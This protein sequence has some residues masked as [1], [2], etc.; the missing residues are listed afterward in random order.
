[1][2]RY[3]FGSLKKAV[4]TMGQAKKDVERP[5]DEVAGKRQQ[6]N[7]AKNGGKR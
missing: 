7:Q 6:K 3:G 1:M 4:K 5:K 2:A